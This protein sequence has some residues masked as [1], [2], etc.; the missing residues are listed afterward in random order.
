MEDFPPV[1]W[2]TNRRDG[3]AI[4]GGGD[5]LQP[6]RRRDG[7]ATR[8]LSRRAGAL[9]QLV[10]GR[11]H[12]TRRA[13]SVGD[14]RPR[15]GRAQAATESSP[16]GWPTRYRRHRDAGAEARRA[17][18]TADVP[19]W[20][21]TLS[22]AAAVAGTFS[23]CNLLSLNESQQ[24]DRDRLKETMRKKTFTTRRSFLG[25]AG[26]GGLALVSGSAWAGPSIELPLPGGPRARALTTA[27]PQKATMILQRTRPPLLET[28]F[29]FDRALHPQRP[30]LR[31]LALGRHPDRDRRR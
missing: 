8:V 16:T 20:P 11:A 29:G 2:R 27:F 13:G 5:V 1:E 9:E 25:Q 30:V 14:L 17:E 19:L 4:A 21:G 6:A 12:S 24:T 18:A 3:E 7:T 22:I 28:P 31:T 10:A 15:P 23:T 26:A